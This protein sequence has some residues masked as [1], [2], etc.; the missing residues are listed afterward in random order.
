[1]SSN[2]VGVSHLLPLN[3]ILFVGIELI[4]DLNLR[5]GVFLF[6]LILTILINIKKELF[7]QT[8]LNQKNFLYKI[9]FLGI[10]YFLPIIILPYY[11]SVHIL[12]PLSIISGIEIDNYF[13]EHYPI[14]DHKK[15]QLLRNS[16]IIYMFFLFFVL[17]SFK[18]M[19]L[20]HVQF[21][22]FIFIFI[23]SLIIIKNKIK[24][25]I[26]SKY[27]NILVLMILILSSQFYTHSLVIE[28]SDFQQN[29]LTLEEM[30]LGNYLLNLDIKG[31]LISMHHLIARR[32]SGFTGI[33][34]YYDI[35]GASSLLIHNNITSDDIYTTKLKLEKFQSNPILY[36]YNSNKL[37]INM[38]KY[39]LSHSFNDSFS[40]KLLK[41]Q[42]TDYIIS[43]NFNYGNFTDVYSNVKSRFFAD[44]V[45]MEKLELSFSIGYYELYRIIY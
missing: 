31:R 4:V 19:I 35:S 8:Y 9:M 28:N 3:N 34:F 24:F 45:Q 12:P 18:K 6:I 37:T 10:V 1:M 25:N 2:F 32:L 11:Y 36:E 29:H 15:K 7:N 14:I 44:L 13:S 17:P 33:P 42:Q 27:K 40:Q 41:T 43:V 22:Q 5:N 30:D 16:S 23:F 26:I 39:I 20:F 21:F 38:R